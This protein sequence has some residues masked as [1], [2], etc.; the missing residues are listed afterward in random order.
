MTQ[1]YAAIQNGG[2]LVSPHVGKAVKAQDGEVVREISPAPEGKVEFDATARSELLRGFR[3][4]TGPDGT[5]APA[6]KNSE[7]D[8]VGKSGTGERYNKDPVNWFAGW[9]EGEEDPIVV[10]VMV[11]GGGHSEVTAAPAVRK[12]LEAHHGVESS[13]APSDASI[14]AAYANSGVQ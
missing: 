9:A 2:T 12:I 13:N 11:E 5:A 10:V 14:V 4:V 8:V 7:L 1:A 3:M 6:F